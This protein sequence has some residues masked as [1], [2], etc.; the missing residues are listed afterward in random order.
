L[1]KDGR[2]DTVKPLGNGIIHPDA[3]GNNDGTDGSTP[4]E[5]NFTFSRGS[6]LAATR[7]DVNGLIEK[8]RENLVLQSNQ[9]DNGWNKSGITLTS[10]Q[11]GY[12]GSSDAWKIEKDASAYRSVNRGVSISG[13]YTFSVYAKAGTLT[14]LT[15]RDGISQRSRF[16]LSNGTIIENLGSV[17]SKIT[18][19]GS[20]W[21][22]CEAVL[23][24]SSPS[25]QFYP[26]WNEANAGY[27]YVQ[28][29]QAESSLVATDY[30]ET[31]ASTAQA[32]ILEQLP[33][34]D[35]SG[36]ATC[37]ALLLEPQRSNLLTQS[38]Y[39]G[40]S[41]W[42][43]LG[44]SVVSG[45]TSPEGLSNA[46]KLVE[47]SSTGNHLIYQNANITIAIGTA[48]LSVFVKENGRNF[49]QIRTG[50]ASGIT[51]A[52]LYANFDLVNNLVTAQSAGANNA[53]I[54]QYANG[55]KRLSISFTITSGS[56][57][58][59][60]FQTITSGTSVIG[61]SY[62]GDGTS[63]LYLYGAQL[64]AGSYSTS[65]IP[66]YGSAV[67]RSLDAAIIRTLDTKNIITDSG[68]WTAFFELELLGNES[69]NDKIQLTDDSNNPRAYLYRQTAGVSPSWLGSSTLTM[70][71]NNKIV[72]RGNSTQNISFFKNGN[73]AVTLSTTSTGLVF[74]RVNFYGANGAF[75]L[76]QIL[77]FPTTLT[78][79]E[80]IALTS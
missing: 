68:S 79:S 14:T 13:V 52:P 1:V 15:L 47:D 20:G 40:D 66:T 29:A 19:V 41:Y 12:D 6:N 5:G 75:R 42:T 32:G 4:S 60:V 51:N 49:F 25:F 21:Y 28:D 62:T 72:Y 70:N 46:Y 56:Q 38:E 71:T 34:L 43:K 50:S 44:A 39:F 63:G 37:P 54:E 18:D 65:Y 77:L 22:R 7:V 76:K 48:T 27:I 55:W 58:A 61:E 30:I 74:N 26:D 78:D 69:P 53:I 35:Y 8:G 11:A 33:R 73:N 3:T 59:L 31:G 64:E 45:F 24:T 10:G 36:G 67:T 80:C 23:T 2:L 17:T 16:N 57:A 9:F